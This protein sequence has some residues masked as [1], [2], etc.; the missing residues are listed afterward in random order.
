MPSWLRGDVTAYG[1]HQRRRSWAG[2]GF[3]STNP[4]PAQLLC[5]SAKILCQGEVEQI[6][7]GDSHRAHTNT[8]FPIACRTSKIPT[9]WAKPETSSNAI[10]KIR[11][12]EFGPA[13]LMG[14]V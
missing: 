14:Y 13:L 1:H 11:E 2:A 9:S 10:A 6:E 4:A 7:D 12:A 3:S 8:S 5:L